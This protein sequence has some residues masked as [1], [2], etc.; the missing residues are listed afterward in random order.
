MKSSALSFTEVCNSYSG[1]IRNGN[2]VSKPAQNGE[3]RMP[4]QTKTADGQCSVAP[5]VFPSIDCAIKSYD[6][7]KNGHAGCVLTERYRPY[8]AKR[9]D[10]VSLST[11]TCSCP[12]FVATVHNDV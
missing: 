4:G 9:V 11:A 1:E 7:T 5:L 6:S 3:C 10:D 8:D 12:G 2:C